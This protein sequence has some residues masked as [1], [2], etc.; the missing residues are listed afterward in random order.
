M[1]SAG[2]SC[3]RAWPSRWSP[4]SCANGLQLVG[5]L[6]WVALNSSGE[7]CNNA[8]GAENNEDQAAQS[9]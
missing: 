5:S 9:S 6:C 2:A 8:S 4:I 3:K 7:H 1:S